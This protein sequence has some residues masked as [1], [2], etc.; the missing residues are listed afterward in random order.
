MYTSG[1]GGASAMQLDATTF[2][3]DNST[4]MATAT[5]GCFLQVIGHHTMQNLYS[6]CWLPDVLVQDYMGVRGTGG[7]HGV[8]TSPWAWFAS[9]PDQ[10][11]S[12]PETLPL[13]PTGDDDTRPR[14][15]QVGV[16]GGSYYLPELPFWG[17]APTAA[18]STTTVT[19]QQRQLL[20]MQ[21]QHSFYSCSNNNQIQMPSHETQDAAA[22]SLELSLSS[23]WCS[24]YHA[25][26][27]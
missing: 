25:G 24:P 4:A 23:S 8:A 11:T 16:P 2:D 6:P 27:M 20:Q 12:T 9:P 10:R 15:R 3:C 13:F 14:P 26:T 17:A 7:V 22:A 1:S 18:T 21:Q 19:I 5:E